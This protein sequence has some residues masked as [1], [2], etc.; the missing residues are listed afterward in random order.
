MIKWEVEETIEAADDSTATENNLTSTEQQ[1]KHTAADEGENEE[2]SKSSSEVLTV[3]EDEQGSDR[4]ESCDTDNLNCTLEEDGHDGMKMQTES[5]EYDLGGFPLKQQLRE[6][7]GIFLPAKFS[8]IYRRCYEGQITL[9]L[10][11][12]GLVG[13]I[14]L[15]GRSRIFQSYEEV[16]ITGEGL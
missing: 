8:D 15:R 6:T 14:Y 13:C 12:A 11:H 10:M 4:A 3:N 16:F 7:R 1:E 2:G 9:V 5:G